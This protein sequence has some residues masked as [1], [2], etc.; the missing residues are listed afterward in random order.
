MNPS[1]WIY[2]ESDK[3]V[4]V[5]VNPDQVKA[6]F[7]LGDKRKI[8]MGDSYVYTI[9]ELNPLVNELNPPA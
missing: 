6:V 2:V 4:K 5:A 9:D 1:E 7:D 8:D 3:G